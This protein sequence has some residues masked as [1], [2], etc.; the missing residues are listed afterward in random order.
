MNQQ[1]EET[2]PMMAVRTDAGG[3]TLFGLAIANAT[4]FTSSFC[5][6]VIELVAGRV[7]AKYL[8][9][10]LYTWTSIIGVVLAGIAIGNYCGG[11]IADRYAVDKPSARRTLAM[12]F[13]LAGI[14]SF[15]INQYNMLAGKISFLESL[16]WPWRV[17]THVA[18]VFFLPSGMLGTISPVIAKMALDLGRQTGRTLGSVYA[19][20]VVG[21]IF[22]TFITGF[23]FIAVFA[24]STII[25]SVAAVLIATA[26]LYGIASLGKK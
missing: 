25:L 21:S 12:L 8:G 3:G 16:A 1:V 7:V 26:I 6:M 4:V 17:A 2:S 10:S 24:T 11:R 20:G 19:W 5:I 22:G 9:S 18:L 23:Y 15:G 13:L 14:I